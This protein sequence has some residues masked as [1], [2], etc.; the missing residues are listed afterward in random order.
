V[1]SEIL[2]NKDDGEIAA[3]ANIFPGKEFKALFDIPPMED[4]Q[5]DHTLVSVV[6]G[7]T[8][9]PVVRNNALDA[10]TKGRDQQKLK[11]T[12]VEQSFGYVEES[13]GNKHGGKRVQDDADED[14]TITGAPDLPSTKKV[15]I[16]EAALEKKPGGRSIK[17]VQQPKSTVDRLLNDSGPSM[18]VT[19]SKAKQQK[20]WR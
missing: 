7:S 13:T 9:H 19:R 18:V 11:K 17:R 1:N 5:Q 8:E 6:R 14:S 16:K 2:Q 12:K 4:S 10:S 3:A 20:T 15:K